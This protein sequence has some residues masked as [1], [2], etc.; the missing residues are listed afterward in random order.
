MHCKRFESHRGRD[1]A[2]NR[3]ANLWHHDASHTAWKLFRACVV[4]VFAAEGDDAMA[5]EE[6]VTRFVRAREG[7]CSGLMVVGW[8]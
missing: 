6:E 7:G 5:I 3:A 8:R 4:S 2:T 1:I